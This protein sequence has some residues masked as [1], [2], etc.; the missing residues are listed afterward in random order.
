MPIL[1]TDLQK[2][3]LDYADYT[4]PSQN[5]FID[6]RGASGIKALD[7]GIALF[8]I[9]LFMSAAVYSR[10]PN[11]IP[12]IA[13]SVLTAVSLTIA[14]LPV[15]A[16]IA[17]VTGLSNLSMFATRSCRKK[18]EATANEIFDID[19]LKKGIHQNR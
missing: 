11:S 19:L 10:N 6:L 9:P 13:A 14:V 5:E 1:P 2:I 12:I 17:T 16:G 7:N 15:Y 3:V 18:T 8:A 4:P